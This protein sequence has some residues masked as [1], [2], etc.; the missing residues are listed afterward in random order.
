M[1]VSKELISKSL[2]VGNCAE[3]F[4]WSTQMLNPLVG[5]LEKRDSRCTRKKRSKLFKLN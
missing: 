5:L 4:H 1:E 2:S 3:V